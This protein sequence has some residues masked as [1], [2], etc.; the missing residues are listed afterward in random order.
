MADQA[1]R[2]EGNEER[3]GT[4]GSALS[5]RT[6]G[7]T[8]ISIN[9]P[10]TARIT[11]IAAIYTVKS[12]VSFFKENPE[13]V[14]SALQLVFKPWGA[15]IGQVSPGSLNVDL[16]FGSKEQFLK[17]EKDF[18]DGKVKDATE[19]EFRNIGYDAKLNLTLTKETSNVASIE[20][21]KE[22]TMVETKK[23]T[24]VNPNPE[25]ESHGERKAEKEG[26]EK[27]EVREGL[28]GKDNPNKEDFQSPSQKHKVKQEEEN[29]SAAK[30]PK[31]EPA[32]EP[33]TSGVSSTSNKKKIMKEGPV[34]DDDLQILGKAIGNKWDRLARR[35]KIKE[36][37]IEEIDERY[38]T[39]SQ[40]G[41]QMLRLWKTNNGEAADYKTLQDALVHNM[42]Q[43]RDLAEKY[44]FK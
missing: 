7:G 24:F 10:W 37:E 26:T 4:S 1:E 22:S 13:I 33:E 6:A 41:H 18:E 31:L 40:R 23:I 11:M 27:P 14:K 32:V 34:S 44:C 36:D 39:L 38:R 28:Q 12:L 16:N 20:V 2:D 3:P 5:V 9:D 19:K 42:V 29:G 43:R 35:L 21:R 17:F 30:K 25:V 15:V 8:E